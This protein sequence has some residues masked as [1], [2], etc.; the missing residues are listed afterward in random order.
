[1]EAEIGAMQPQARECQQPPEEAGRHREWIFPLEPSRKSGSADSKIS[2]FWLDLWA[3][4][5]LLGSATQF[6]LIFTF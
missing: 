6:V 1:M 4:K 5:F 2:G 3:K